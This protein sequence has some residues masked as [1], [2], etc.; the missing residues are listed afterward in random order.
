MWWCVFTRPGVTRHP[1]ARS[2]FVAA[3]GVSDGPP[4]AV[5]NPPAH[6]AQ[7]PAIS[8]RSS[9]IVTTRSAPATS[10]S[11]GVPSGAGVA[12]GGMDRTLPAGADGVLGV[13][14][15]LTA[16]QRTPALA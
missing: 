10:R 11:T 3:G 8:R 14:T 4:T 5:T 12:P 6:A 9:S 7:P 16:A 13:H 1:S 15:A 2:T